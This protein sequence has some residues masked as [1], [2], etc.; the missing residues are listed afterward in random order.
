MRHKATISLLVLALALSV[1]VPALAYFSWWDVTPG[2]IVSTGVWGPLTGLEVGTSKAIRNSGP[3]PAD[4]FP[5]ASLGADDSIS[6]DFGE[7]RPG[8]ANA[9]PDVFRVAA[10]SQDVH[11]EFSIEGDAAALVGSI[12][13]F[14]GTGD[15]VSESVTRRVYIK[16]DVPLDYPPGDVVGTLVVSIDGGVEVY[17]LPVLITVRP[18]GQHG[19]STPR[20]PAS[21]SESSSSSVT[22]GPASD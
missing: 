20:P 5:I 12:K 16:L 2:N 9:S 21:S 14:P 13:L 4:V 22:S 17:R 6:L 10:Y 11:V 18:S 19:D 15:V 7:V 8:N 1:G 3:G